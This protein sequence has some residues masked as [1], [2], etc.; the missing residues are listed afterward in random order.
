MIG[1]KGNRDVWFEERGSGMSGWREREQRLL[2]GRNGIR[3][4]WLEGRGSGMSG[5]RQG[6]RYV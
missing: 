1:G 5:W 2:V 3:D 6:I 4:V